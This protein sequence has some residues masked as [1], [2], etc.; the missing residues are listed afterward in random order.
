[1]AP[2][3]PRK[4]KHVTVSEQEMEKLI[5]EAAQKAPPQVGGY[6]KKAAPFLAKGAVYVQMAVPYTVWFV[7]GAIEIY[8]VLPMQAVWAMCGLILCFFGGMF[9][10]IIATVEAFRQCGWDRTELAIKQLVEEG[11]LVLQ[12]EA[13]DRSQSSFEEKVDAKELLLR[14]AH[15]VMSTCDPVKVNQAIN[16]LYASWIAVLAVLKVHFA[17]TVALS[18]SIAQVLCPGET[19]DSYDDP[20]ADGVAVSAPPIQGPALVVCEG[21]KAAMPEE[22]VRKGWAEVVTRWLVRMVSVSVAWF[23]A[24]YISAAHSAIRGGHM[25]ARESYGLCKRKGWLKDF[26]AWFGKDQFTIAGWVVAFLGF[27]AQFKLGFRAPF[28]LNLLLFPAQFL[29]SVIQWMV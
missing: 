24:R 15:L 9:P 27:A 6:V 28:P 21:L 2:S 11:N 8:G 26:P 10:V 17:R 29:E 16:G 1:M 23:L 18:M 12:Q 4:S 7:Q 5:I 13:K 20:P 22:Y 14:K 19:S 3:L 25:F